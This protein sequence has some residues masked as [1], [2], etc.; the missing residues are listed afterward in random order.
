MHLKHIQLIRSDCSTQKSKSNIII[1]HNIQWPIISI[2]AQ[3]QLK[4]F[5]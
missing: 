4:D 3:T 2:I 5:I 1:T